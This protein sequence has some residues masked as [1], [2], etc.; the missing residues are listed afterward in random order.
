LR[1][2]K[3]LLQRSYSLPG[4]AFLAP[5]AFVC[6]NLIVYWAGW[7]I[8]STLMVAMLIGYVLMIVSAAF[9]LNPNQPR[10]DWDAAIWIFPYLIGLGAISYFGGFG[11][12]G[13]IGGIRG[14]QNVLVGGHGDLPFWY[15]LGV[16]AVF[17][18]VIYFLAIWKRLP[19]PQVDEY[20]RDVYPPPTEHD[21]MAEAAH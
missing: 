5:L 7:Q 8:Y 4:A 13:I 11:P 2:S 20:V 15:D 6:A 9:H 21:V 16:V 10:V 3:P 12:G 18:L 17:S 1:K 19:E 14:F